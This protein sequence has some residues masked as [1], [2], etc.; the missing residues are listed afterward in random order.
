MVAEV[1]LAKL[2]FIKDKIENSRNYFSENNNRYMNSM[3]FVYLSNLTSSDK[4]KLTLLQKPT[5]EFNV[6][7]ALISKQRGEFAI[8]EPAFMI[9]AAD[10]ASPDTITPEFLETLEIVGGHIDELISSSKTDNLPFDTYGQ[11]LGGGFGAWKVEI[12]YASPKSFDLK[13]VLKRMVNPTLVGFDPLA[14]DSHKGDGEY[15]Y[16]LFPMSKE[17]FEIEYGK[18]ILEKA[19]FSRDFSAGSFNWNYTNGTQKIVT[20]C[21]FYLKT[22]KRVKLY[23]LSNGAAVTQKHYD[24]SMKHWLEKAELKQPPIVLEERWSYEESIEKYTLCGQKVIKHEDTIFSM[25][26][27][28]FVDGDSQFLQDAAQNMVKQITF[29]WLFHAE[30]TQRL[31]NFAG[32]TAAYE[33]E[34]MLTSKVKIP[35]EGIPDEYAKVYTN[36]QDASVWVYNAFRDDDPNVPLPPPMEVQRTPTPPIVENTFMNMAQHMQMVT[37]SYD[38]LMATNDK[39]VSGRA[40]RNGAI[41]SASASSPYMVNYMKAMNRVAELF[42]DIFPKIYVTP[43][44]IPI[45]QKD[46]KRSYHTIERGP[47]GQLN[48]SYDPSDLKVKVEAGVSNEVQKQISMETVIN[49]MQVSGPIGQFFADEGLPVILDNLDIKGSE[50]LKSRVPEW[51]QKQE[52]ASQNQAPPPEIALAQQQLEMD[53]QVRMAQVQQQAQ[54]AQE[55][56]AVDVAKI[57]VEQER[58]NLDREELEAKMTM[59]GI[60]LRQAENRLDAEEAREAIDVALQI[61]K[62]HRERS[63]PR[64]AEE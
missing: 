59:E 52:Q 32:Q 46:G 49:L 12:D 58:L 31:I 11:T 45:R 1:H 47:D 40:I 53:T 50:Y 2:K 18:G 20:V 62:E 29:P 5:I 44:T 25:L 63:S 10:S 7:K 3:S 51:L 48:F 37:G 64:L 23:R 19:S 36:I 30:G 9:N 54:K 34:T 16:E 8:H 60:K 43:R 28:I 13:P 39:N 41:Q 42:V 55:Q 35:L 57:A 14:L 21:E 27:I 4:Q 22:K 6:C 24:E 15:C 38:G 26:P 33:I 61:A 56:H 17:E